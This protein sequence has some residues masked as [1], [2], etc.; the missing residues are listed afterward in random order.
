MKHLIGYWYVPERLLPDGNRQRMRSGG[1]VAA[2]LVNLKSILN[3]V[4]FRYVR[5][6]RRPVLVNV[7]PDSSQEGLSPE[8]RGG[9]Q[10][11]GGE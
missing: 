3:F 9:H 6:L 11:G 4:S 10:N 5:R 8:R 7:R 2:V 1:S